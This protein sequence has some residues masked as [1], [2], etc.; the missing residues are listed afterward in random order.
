MLVVSFLYTEG[1]RE[2]GG[3]VRERVGRRMRR[4]MRSA[5]EYWEEN[6]G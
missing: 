6:V 4:K 2:N 1:T 5:E 3:Q